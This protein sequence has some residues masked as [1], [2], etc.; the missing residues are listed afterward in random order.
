MENFDDREILFVCV[1]VCFMK[2]MF[3]FDGKSVCLSSL[4]KTILKRVRYFIKR[5]AHF[6]HTLI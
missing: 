1:F 5:C 2:K 3:D 6:T 4:I